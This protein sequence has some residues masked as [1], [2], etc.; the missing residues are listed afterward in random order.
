MSF[1]ECVFPQRSRFIHGV[2]LF[3]FLRLGGKG[4]GLKYQFR[5]DIHKG[6]FGD[7][8]LRPLCLFLGVLEH[9]DVLEDARC[10]TIVGDN[11]RGDVDNVDRM[12]T[13]TTQL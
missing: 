2:I 12:D 1:N 10:I 6:Y 4:L 9:I 3:P 11:F 7:G 5:G 8:E 13:T